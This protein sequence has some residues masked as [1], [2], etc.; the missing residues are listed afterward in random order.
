MF[1]SD[2]EPRFAAEYDPSWLTA[3]QTHRL[4]LYFIVEFRRE[5]W[6]ERP[7]SDASPNRHKLQD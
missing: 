5:S 7:P 3:S 6:P 4:L 1:F 2:H